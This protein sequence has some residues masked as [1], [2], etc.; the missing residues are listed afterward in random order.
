VL[1]RANLSLE[2]FLISCQTLVHPILHGEGGGGER[3]DILQYTPYLL[4]PLC[5]FLSSACRTKCLV[6]VFDLILNFLIINWGNE[7]IPQFDDDMFLEKN[8]FILFCSGVY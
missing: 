2:T 6:D 4:L 3:G 7:V 1:T 5:N 8:D